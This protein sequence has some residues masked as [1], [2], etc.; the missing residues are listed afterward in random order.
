ME[1]SFILDSL[2]LLRVPRHIIDVIWACM[3]LAFMS[4]NWEERAS[5]S[6]SPTRGL[7]QGDPM[8]LL[9]FIIAIER[10]SHLVSDAVHDASWIPLKF[11]RGGSVVSH[12]MFADDILLVAKA[13]SPSVRKILEILELFRV[14]SG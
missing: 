13:S 14:C 1:W 11:S 8:S 7:W 2:G 4:V 5:Q 3:G 6:F 9:L 12:L 10:L